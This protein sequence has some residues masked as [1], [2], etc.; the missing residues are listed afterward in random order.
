MINV[1]ATFGRGIAQV[2][3]HMNL[4]FVHTFPTHRATQNTT[5]LLRP[6]LFTLLHSPPKVLAPI[7]TCPNLPTHIQVTDDDYNEPTAPDLVV[8]PARD[9]VDYTDEMQMA[10]DE[11][12][13]A[14]PLPML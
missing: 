12:E 1:S 2:G 5:P 8:A 4:L 14:R 6:L 13:S 3:R 10:E 9:A 7:H 11:A